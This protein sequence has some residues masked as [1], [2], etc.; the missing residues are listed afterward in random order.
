MANPLDQSG[1]GAETTR[2]KIVQ[3]ARELVV[4]HG[5]GGVSTGQVL[6]RAEVSRGGLYH[7][8]AGK[9]E[10]MAAVLEAVETDFTERLAAA[11]A[12]ASSPFAALEQ[13]VQWYL[14]ECLRSREL[15]RVGLYEGRQA[16]GWTAWRETIAPYG[17]SILA[18]GLDAAIEA[19]ELE[20]ADPRA[21]AHMILALLH[22]SVTMILDSEDRAA[23]RERVG[24]TAAVV[25]SGLR[26]RA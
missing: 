24:A 25:I 7:H 3:A 9:Q 5:Y 14:D 16:L 11:V 17:L 15:Q 18:A 21:L 22:E 12:D 10:L 6:Q 23:E 8:F 26:K 1:A 19:G 20:P 4:E 2:E 13:G